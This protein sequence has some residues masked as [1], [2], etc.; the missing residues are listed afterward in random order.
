LAIGDG[1]VSINPKLG[2]WVPVCAAPREKKVLSGADFP[3]ALKVLPIRERLIFRLATI[4]E[5]WPEEL[6]GLQLRDVR[7]HSVRVERRVYRGM[8]I[9]QKEVVPAAESAQWLR[10]DRD[11]P[12]ER[13]AAD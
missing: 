12:L 4:E 5:M 10:Y 11:S 2:L 9:R 1:A 6:L 13:E 3:R 7:E 8:S